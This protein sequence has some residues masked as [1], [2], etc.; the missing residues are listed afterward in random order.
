LTLIVRPIVLRKAK[1][2]VHQHHRH[3]DP[4]HAWLFGCGAYQGERMVG[5]GV[6][7]RPVAEALDDGV[8]I[9]VV[10]TCTDGTRNANSLLYGALWRAAKALGYVLGVTYIQAGET[11]ASL[12]AVGWTKAAELPPRGDWAE[13]S[14]KLKHLR[15]KAQASLL[16]EPKKYT[17]NVARERWEIRA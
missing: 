13:S 1:V 12:K 6:A 8:T 14:V 4:P 11:G 3:N 7:G 16:D 2:F 5:V 10:R 15:V 9:E 17:G